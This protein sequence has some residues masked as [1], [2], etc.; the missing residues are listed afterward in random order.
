MSEPASQ[1][2]TV[3]EA[4]KYFNRAERTIQHWCRTGT[5]I[6]FNYQ[7]IRARSTRWLIII[8]PSS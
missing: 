2:L 7:V 5:L 8:P 4:A 3:A 1:T 6:A